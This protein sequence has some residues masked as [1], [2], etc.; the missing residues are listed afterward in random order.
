MCSP[1]ALMLSNSGWELHVSMPIPLM[2][3]TLTMQ[4]TISPKTKKQ[5]GFDRESS[6]FMRMWP[7]PCV[8]SVQC[9]STVTFTERPL[10]KTA[11]AQCFSNLSWGAHTAAHLVC[12]PYLTH[13]I[14]I[15]SSLAETAR[16]DLDV[17]NEET[18]C[19]VVVGVSKEGFEKLCSTLS[20][21]LEY[22]IL[23]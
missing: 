20:C 23:N 17:S 4:L 8:P 9:L 10:H 21:L 16:L 2:S 11:L 7:K 1:C 12:F 13:L 5:K 19:A 3:S 6:G 14:K 22:A 15:T 18:K